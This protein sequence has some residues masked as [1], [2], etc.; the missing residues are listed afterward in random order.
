MEMENSLRYKFSDKIFKRV[1]PMNER[2]AD[3]KA[4]FQAPFDSLHLVA[5]YLRREKDRDES[6]AC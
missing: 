2:S 5:F 4:R 6:R 1:F 3:F